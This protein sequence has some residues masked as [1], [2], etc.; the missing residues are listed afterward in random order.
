MSHAYYLG[1][2]PPLDATV[3]STS[4]GRWGRWWANHGIR[5]TYESTQQSTPIWGGSVPE[6]IVANHDHAD[7]YAMI[8][9]YYFSNNT[10]YIGYHFHQR[11]VPLVSDRT[12][13]SFLYKFVVLLHWHTR[14]TLCRYRMRKHLFL[15]I[16]RVVEL[17]KS[18]FRISG[19]DLMQQT[20]WD[21]HHF[22][23]HTVTLCIRAC[24]RMQSMSACISP[25]RRPL[26][27]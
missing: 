26:K 22:K 1:G 18:W 25:S 21:C 19:V 27:P 4:H 6:H 16:V 9:F 17:R 5:A 11:Y 23:K 14:S 24:T 7:G 13:L 8:M 3:A 10:V 15:R 20:R 12:K 2:Y